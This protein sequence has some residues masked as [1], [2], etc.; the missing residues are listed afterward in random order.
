MGW[1]C[2]FARWPCWFNF[3]LFGPESI[4]ESQEKFSIDLPDGVIY[5]MACQKAVNNGFRLINRPTASGTMMLLMDSVNGPEPFSI[6]FNHNF[7][8]AF[9]GEK[10]RMEEHYQMDNTGDEI[11]DWMTLNLPMWHGQLRRM[12]LEANPI[13]YLAQFLKETINA[14]LN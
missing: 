6:I 14:N 3:L 1:R 7:A 13:Q 4:M 5:Q 11:K 12:V 2:S 10:T 8:K 9:W